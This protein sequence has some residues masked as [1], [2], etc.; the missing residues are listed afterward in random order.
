MRTNNERKTDIEQALRFMHRD[1][2][3]AVFGRT[4]V[5]RIGDEYFTAVGD[6]WVPTDEKTIPEL[7]IS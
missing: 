7:A 4:H 2:G 3:Y 5:L 1:N 6:E